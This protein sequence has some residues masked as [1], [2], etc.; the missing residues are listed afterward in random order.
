LE[1]WELNRVIADTDYSIYTDGSL[2]N[3]LA[4]SAFFVTEEAW[5]EARSLG[6]IDCAF[7]AEIAAISMATLH[8]IVRGVQGRHIKI[9]SDSKGALNVLQTYLF[10]SKIHLFFALTSFKFYPF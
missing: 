4:G 5:G 1:D 8:C 10:D 3:G 7:V 6:P 2:R 9:C